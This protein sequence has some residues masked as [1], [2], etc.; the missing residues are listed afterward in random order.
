MLMEIVDGWIFWSAAGSISNAKEENRLIDLTQGRK[1]MSVL[2]TDSR[3]VLLSYLKP[4]RLQPRFDASGA[5]DEE[6]S[7]AE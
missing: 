4:E 2:F 6:P 1:T 5:A 3:H 7:Q